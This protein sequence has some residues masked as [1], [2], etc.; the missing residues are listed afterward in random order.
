MEKLLTPETFDFFARYLLAGF[1]FLAA[2]ARFIV[3][4]RPKPTEAVV[5]AVILSL[6][7]QMMFL[8][9]LTVFPD[10]LSGGSRNIQL[11]SE[12]VAL[13]AISGALFGWLLGRNWMPDGFRRLFMPVSRPAAQAY[14]HAFTVADTPCFVLVAYTDN[15]E[16]YGYFGEYSLASS[17]LEAGGIFLESLYL[18]GE[19]GEWLPADPP[20]SAWLSLQDARSIEFF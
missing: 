20:R 11:I 4:E 15:R 13:P 19:N 10:L 6:I 12:V 9:V 18:P 5:E 1:V 14:Q 7:N 8:M 16:V 17:N 3:G 2:R